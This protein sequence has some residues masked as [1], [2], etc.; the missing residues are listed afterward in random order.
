MTLPEALAIAKT[1]GAPPHHN[2]AIGFAADGST[3][4]NYLEARAEA[5]RIIQ[6]SA[7]SAAT[8]FRPQ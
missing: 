7:K 2:V 5:Q 4:H 8:S 6:E 1:Y 3:S